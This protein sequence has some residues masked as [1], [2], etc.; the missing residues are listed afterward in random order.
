MRFLD[1]ENSGKS[2]GGKVTDVLEISPQASDVESG[3]AVE[4]VSGVNI[5]WKL[6]GRCRLREGGAKE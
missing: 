2:V 4:R 3:E 1:K 5:L 6:S